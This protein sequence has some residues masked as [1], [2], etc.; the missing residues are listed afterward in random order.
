[1]VIGKRSRVE[2]GGSG[3]KGMWRREQIASNTFGFYL[4]GREQNEHIIILA[5][6][7]NLSA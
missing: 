1:M 7:S 6:L 2:T 3:S 5:V 4:A